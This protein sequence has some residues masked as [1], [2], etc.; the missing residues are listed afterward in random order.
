MARGNSRP[1]MKKTRNPRSSHAVAK[2]K[3]GAQ[4]RLT[5]RPELLLFA[6]GGQPSSDDGELAMAAL[7]SGRK[8]A[9]A[10]EQVAL[11]KTRQLRW[12]TRKHSEDNYAA[13]GLVGPQAAKDLF[14]R[15][16]PRLDLDAILD[17]DSGSGSDSD[18]DAHQKR[19]RTRGTFGTARPLRQYRGVGNDGG[20]DDS[21]DSD[22]E[23]AQMLPAKLTRAP[24]PKV[25]KLSEGEQQYYSA[26]VQK[27]GDNYVAM[28]RDIKLN[29]YQHG[30]ALLEKKCKIWRARY[31]NSAP[32]G[33]GHALVVDPA[34]GDVDWSKT[35]K[36][37]GLK[38]HAQSTNARHRRRKRGTGKR[39]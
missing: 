25:P 4:H 28:A 7:S 15:V 30:P 34:T 3:R 33:K 16:D 5:P 8:G 31:E 37:Q 36:K 24:P 23:L 20:S 17:S 26:L 13:A 6:E 2:H 35:T 19:I 12:D 22:G 39:A 21:S 18:S 9:S 10:R 29:C 38:A 27:H 14:D 1:K 11:L 32:V